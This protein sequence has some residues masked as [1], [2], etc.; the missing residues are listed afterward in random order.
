MQEAETVQN[1]HKYA[2]CLV[3]IKTLGTKTFSYLIPDDMK[4]IIKIGQPVTLPFGKGERKIKGYVVG[5]SNY[6]EAGIKAKYIDE[7]LDTEPMFSL[8]YLKM[9]E[10]VANYYFSDLPTVLKTAL[11]EKFFQKN[12]KNY[13]K[14]N[15]ELKVLQTEK[16]KDKHTLSPEQQKIYDD[17]K[18]VNA[19]TSLLYGITG[20]GKTEIYF[21]LIEDTIKEG[22]NVLF[23]APEIALVSQLTARTIKRFGKTS[24]GIWHSSI[25]E[26]EKYKVWQKLRN[27]EIKILF[28]ARSSVFAPVKNLGLIIIDEENDPAYKQTMPAPRYS[29]I[30]VAKKLA[31]LNNDSNGGAK[32]ILGSATPDIKSYYEAKNSNS[33][34]VLNKRYNNAELPK[35]KIIDMRMERGFGNNGIF[36]KYLIDEIHKTVK[37]KNQVIL[38]INRRGFSSYTQCMECSEIIECPKCAIPLIYHSQTQSHRCHYCNHEIKNLTVC[39]KCGAEGTLENFGTGTQRVEE[40]AGKIFPDYTIQRLDSDSLTKKNEHFEILESF[41]NG[42]IDILIGTQ[43]IAKGLDNPNVTLVGVINADLSF[44]LPD[45]RSSERGFSLLCQVA[46]RSG[47][48]KDEGKVIFQTYNN[49]NI[50]LDK[51]REQDYDSFFENEIEIREAFDYPPFSKIIRVILSSDNNFRAEKSAMEIAM[52]LKE[53]I[54]KQSLTERLIVMGPAPCVLEKIR[55]EYRFNLIIKNKLDEKG[56]NIILS[57]L[58]KIIL[59]NDIK[60]V[61]DVDPSDIL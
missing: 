51:A 23:L 20:S 18:K 4:D 38:L 16:S 5:F 43:M 49:S 26:A 45:F 14:P 58:R 47:R 46:G 25:T 32:L 39:P 40:I 2:L 52:R 59:P 53:W 29:A 17:I 34:F 6:L 12:L 1:T 41:Q 7:I 24:V 33:L 48:G 13:R 30:E 27:D 61:V 44:N 3:D 60:M 22:K 21:K 54:D 56:H 11:P 19:K 57:F 37:N 36:S 50:F 42:E 55:G 31:E 15:K 8:E 28:G 10:W 35:V 9:L